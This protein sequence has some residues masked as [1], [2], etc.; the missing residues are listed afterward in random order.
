MRRL[1]RT[2]LI[3]KTDA[4]VVDPIV[5]S[6]LERTKQWW[7]LVDAS[8]A[9]LSGVLDTGDS[10]GNSAPINTCSKDADWLSAHREYLQDHP[11]CK[12]RKKG[13]SRKKDQ[14]SL[15]QQ[16]SLE[17]RKKEAT[18][19]FGPF[20]LVPIDHLPDMRT[21]ALTGSEKRTVGGYRSTRLDPLDPDDA[22]QQ[23]YL[24]PA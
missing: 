21:R 14:R 1:P 6:T 4:C 12:E 24:T 13:K 11:E 5:S 18:E 10:D 9:A 3:C 7:I 17:K 23:W 20:F 8:K 2:L 15:I 16:R 19:S 22:N